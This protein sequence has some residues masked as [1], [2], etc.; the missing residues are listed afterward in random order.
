MWANEALA[1][2]EFDANVGFIVT[3]LIFLFFIAREHYYDF[4]KIP[5]NSRGM[6]II[7]YIIIIFDRLKITPKN[8]KNLDKDI[9]FRKSF[10]YYLIVSGFIF[11]FWIKIIGQTGGS[12]E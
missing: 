2:A 6:T 8:S 10:H 4:R 7:S 3:I 9:F 11:F 5:V 1:Q 12:V